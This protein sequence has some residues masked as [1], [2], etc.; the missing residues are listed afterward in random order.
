MT[1]KGNCFVSIVI[2]LLGAVF[3]WFSGHD[4]FTRWIVLLCGLAFVV[5]AAVS[6]LGMFVS[7]K[8]QRMSALMRV[9]Q[10][11][12][13]VAGLVLGLCII[14]MPDVFRSLLFYPF[15]ALLVAGGLFQEFQVSH[16]NRSV[17]Y[18]GWLHVVPVLLI[19]AGVVLLCVPALHELSAERWMLLMVGISAILFGV[20][21]ICVS[22]MARRLPKRLK[23]GEAAEPAKE[24]APKAAETPKA[25]AEAPA[26]EP[27]KPA[28]PEAEEASEAE[29]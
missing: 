27:V 7:G 20:N 28:A 9:V 13:G 24:E 26:T 17:D 19:A 22:V 18:P 6:I 11:I 21:G 1:N 23:E 12:C 10:I 4:H 29:K 25:I 15:G 3:C 5:P 16:R 2:L 8:A 14:F